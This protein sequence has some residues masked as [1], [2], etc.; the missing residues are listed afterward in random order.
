MTRSILCLHSFSFL[1]R[2]ICLEK[3]PSVVGGHAIFIFVD[4]GNSINKY[5]IWSSNHKYNLELVYEGF[6]AVENG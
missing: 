5:K 3:F 2:E 1:A 4:F 6:C